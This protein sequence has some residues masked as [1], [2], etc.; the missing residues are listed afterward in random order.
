MGV[1]ARR[2][3]PH[4]GAGVLGAA[5]HRGRR[6]ARRRR[7][8]RMPAR[9]AGRRRQAGRRQPLVRRARRHDP[10]G[11]AGHG[12]ELQREPERRHGHRQQ[13]GRLLRRDVPQVPERH[14]LAQ[15]AARHRLPGRRAAAVD[16]RQRPGA[17][18]AV[19]HARR[20]VRHR[21]H[22]AGRCGRPTRSTT[23]STRAT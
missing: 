19:V 13:P 14:R 17:P 10:A 16:D 9:G 22:P 11:H 5:D 15:P 21:R 12:D 3:R 23:C 1:A 6:R 4:R 2:P 18:G 7:P 20:R 8:A